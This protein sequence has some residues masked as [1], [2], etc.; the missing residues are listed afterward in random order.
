LG[1]EAVSRSAVLLRAS[2]GALPV[3]GDGTGVLLAGDAADDVG[4][5]LGGWSVTWQGGHGATTVGTTLKAALDARLPG[6]VTYDAG[7][8]FA[9]GTR[10]PVGIVGGGRQPQ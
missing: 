6:R 4:A 2:S 9:A 5:Q 1:A 8:A 7:G 10:A 3:A